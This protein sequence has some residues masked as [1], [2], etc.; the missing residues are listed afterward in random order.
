MK[1]YKVTKAHKSHYPSPIS[2]STGEKVLIGIYDDEYSG[3]V[4]VV[5]SDNNEGWAP[6]QYLQIKENQGVAIRSYNAME[7]NT[8]TG[9]VVSVLHELNEWGWAK[10]ASNIY[11]W[12]PLHTLK[13]LKVIS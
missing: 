2:F 11:G 5:T 10:N 9:E 7:L 4:R 12:V 6:V 8:T 3:W 13:K 1:Y